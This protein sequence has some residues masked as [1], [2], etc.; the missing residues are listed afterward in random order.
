MYNKLSLSKILLS[1]FSLISLLYFF[2]LAPV[3]AAPSIR[4]DTLGQLNSAAGTGGAGFDNYRDPRETAALI[5]RSALG[6]V[7][8]IFMVLSLYAGFL[9][10]T[11]GGE[12]EKVTK[13]TG[14][15]KMAV[16]GLIIILA[17]YSLTNFVVY[18]LLRSTTGGSEDPLKNDFC[19]K[20]PNDDAC[21]VSF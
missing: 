8:M 15:I 1:V 9:W 12:E 19:I 11:A 3:F 13:A 16:I 21:I 18:R 4:E 14:I 7:G 2:K 6:L 10:M 17:A 20:N 5:I